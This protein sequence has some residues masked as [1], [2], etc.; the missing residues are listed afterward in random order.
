RSMIGTV[1]GDWEGSIRDARAAYADAS[2]IGNRTV[3]AEAAMYT[4]YGSLGA[5]RIADVAP[6]LDEAR[7]LATG[8]TDFMRCLAMSVKALLLFITGDLAA[9]IALTEESLATQRRRNDCEG[10]GLTLS[11]L[12]QMTFAKGDLQRAMK[13]YGEA[14]DT[15]GKVGDKPEIARVYCELGWAAL[16]AKEVQVAKGAFQTA[17]RCYEE[18]GSARGTGLALMG[19]AAVDAADGHPERAITIAQAATAYSARTGVVIE[20]AMD[21]GVVARIDAL[22]ESI[23]KRTLDNL[24]QNADALTPSQVLA[25]VAEAT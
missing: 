3:L 2:A 6:A 16:A 19:L 11:F 13:L 15:F 4:G 5:G 22:K 24:L 14:L 10:G 9:G 17:V 23:P 7:E 8:T 21:P 12:A 18:V 25:M 20:H 1:I